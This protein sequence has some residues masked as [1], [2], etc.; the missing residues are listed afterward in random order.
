M[1]LAVISAF[2]I[3]FAVTAWTL[4]PQS[5]P[6]AALEPIRPLISNELEP[7]LT[8]HVPDPDLPTEPLDECDLTYLNHCANDPRLPMDSRLEAVHQLFARYLRPPANL[9]RV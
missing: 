2:F 8:R 6:V 3:T 9:T 4:T 1:R 5:P 7:K